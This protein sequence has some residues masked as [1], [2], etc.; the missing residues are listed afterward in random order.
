[1]SLTKEQYQAFE[2]IVGPDYISDDPA[3][4]DSYTFPMDITSLHMG[5]CYKVF[6][7]RGQAVLLPGSTEEVQSIVR[8]C[9][10]YKIKFKASS[11]FW[12]AM[13]FPAHDDVLQIDMRRMD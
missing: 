7:P 4:L 2:D 5:P 6:T 10:K 3:L 13:G 12:G 1:M 9:N 11:T 8:L